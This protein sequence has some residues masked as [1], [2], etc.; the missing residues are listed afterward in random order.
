[1]KFLWRIVERQEEIVER[2]LKVK[3]LIKLLEIKQLKWLNRGSSVDEEKPRTSLR[4]WNSAVKMFIGD[5]SYGY[6][7]Q[8]LQ[9]TD[10]NSLVVN[11]DKK[12]SVH[13]Y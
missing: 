2:N 7:Q 3:P 10:R 5:E 1:M 6:G 4:D 12:T 13:K 11:A 9:T 8:R